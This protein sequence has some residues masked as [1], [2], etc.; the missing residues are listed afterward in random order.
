MSSLA[1]ARTRSIQSDVPNYSAIPDLIAKCARAIR[2]FAIIRGGFPVFSVEWAVRDPY[3]RSFLFKRK[4]YLVLLY[5]RAL[6]AS[7]TNKCRSELNSRISRPLPRDAIRCIP[8]TMKFRSESQYIFP[9]Y[10]RR[11]AAGILHCQWEI[12]YVWVT[13]LH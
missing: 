13:A 5:S 12:M 7:A 2:K 9:D 10:L 3:F 8:K 6:I 1:N 11:V 4:H